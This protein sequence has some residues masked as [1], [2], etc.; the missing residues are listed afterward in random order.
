MAGAF[1]QPSQLVRA[2]IVYRHGLLRDVVARALDD[3]GVK[4]TA[5]I[6]VEDLSIE[7]LEVL[8]PEVIVLDQA[9]VGLVDGLSEATLLNRSPNSASRVITVSVGDSI[10]LACQK[11]VVE[12]ASL[13]DLVATTLGLDPSGSVE[14][15]SS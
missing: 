1:R 10:L 7:T 15:C 5:A 9:A 6:P 4:V 12:G 14:A 2:V 8:Q 3:A 13:E 11:R